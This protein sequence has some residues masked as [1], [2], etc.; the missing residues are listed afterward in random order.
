MTTPGR[1]TLNRIWL[2][3]G[4]VWLYSLD[5]RGSCSLVTGCRSETLTATSN[6]GVS[7]LVHSHRQ[8]IWWKVCSFGP[9][10]SLLPGLVHYASIDRSVPAPLLPMPSFFSRF[11]ILSL[12]RKPLTLRGYDLSSLWSRHKIG[13]KFVPR[14]RN[15]FHIYWPFEPNLDFQTKYASVGRGLEL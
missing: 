15:I 14:P 4:K 2:S 13:Y 9:L 5:S 10:P 7:D 6:G 1:N 12:N 8:K 3:T 11:V